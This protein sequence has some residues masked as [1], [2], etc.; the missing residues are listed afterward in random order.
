MLLID[1]SW[2]IEFIRLEGNPALREQVADALK[3]GDAY[4]CDMVRLE[5]QR[6]SG[7]STKNLVPQLDDT[8]PLLETSRAVW[9]RACELARLARQSGKP[10]PNTD[11]LIFAVAQV[12]QVEIGHKDRHFDTLLHLVKKR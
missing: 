1:T 6:A 2:W 9:D 4:W 12:H 8:L 5:L 3:S 7:K 10:V 11:I